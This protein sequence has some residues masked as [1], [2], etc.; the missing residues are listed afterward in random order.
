MK[1]L[2]YR[3]IVPVLALCLLWG[4]VSQDPAGQPATSATT[5]ATASV[6][7]Q[8]TAEPTTEP[9]AG[10]TAPEHSALYIP[11]VTVEDVIRYFNEVCLDAE[12]VNAGDPTRLQKW[13]VPLRYYIYGQPTE[14]DMEVL[15]SFT[16]WLNAVEGFPG[17]HPADAPQLANLQ[18]H[19]CGPEEYIDL[20]GDNFHG[21][22]GGVTFWYN[23]ADQIYNAAIGI[24]TDLDQ[25]VRN[26]VILEELYNGLGPVN[27][28][29][30]RLT[31][32]IYTGYSSPQWLSQ[33]DQ[34]ILQLLYHPLMEC[35]MD[36]AQ[37]QEIIR[38]LYY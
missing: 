5:E 1:T 7:T 32:V 27:D 8:P 9:T 25:Q 11:P 29:W 3:G 26:S 34:L 10:S 22:D 36:A 23:G 15:E 28:T 21:T 14:K 18:I 2:I 13:V 30:E 31:S 17:M 4:C 19:F 24:R 12:F 16:S 38:Q 6:T 35:G 20:M 37:C 33:E